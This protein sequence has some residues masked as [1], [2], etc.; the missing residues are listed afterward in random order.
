MI[1][2]V[3]ATPGEQKLLDFFAA[4]GVPVEMDGRKLLFVILPA[5]SIAANN[6]RE[7]RACWPHL[8]DVRSG[9]KQATFDIDVAIAEKI[10]DVHCLD[11]LEYHGMVRRLKIYWADYKE[12]FG[13]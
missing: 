2:Q 7:I 3:T 13:A 8:E 9:E 11:L 1:A 5:S 12:N 6:H 10:P 4:N